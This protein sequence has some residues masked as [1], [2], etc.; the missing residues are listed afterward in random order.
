MDLRA[1]AWMVLATSSVWLS[2]CVSD[3]YN[4][5]NAPTAFDSEG[6]TWDQAVMG[7]TNATLKIAFLNEYLNCTVVQ[8]CCAQPAY[9]EMLMDD[10]TEGA[11][12]DCSS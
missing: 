9:A 5:C 6:C 2:G 7:G 3:V 4:D 10:V 11:D 12:S 1:F 8:A